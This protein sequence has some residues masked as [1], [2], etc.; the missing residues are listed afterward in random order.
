MADATAH[1]IAEATAAQRR[2]DLAG[3]EAA[4]LRAIE[5]APGNV[6]ALSG[7][8][9]L[10]YQAGHHGP[11]AQRLMEAL[12]AGGPTVAVLV[13]L[14][15]ARHGLG[16]HGGAVASYRQALALKPNFATTHNS[17]GV[18]L[19][20]MKEYKQ[21]K[22][23]FADA[24]KCDPNHGRA[25]FNLATVQREAG[26]AADAVA[27]FERACALSPNFSPAFS[28]LGAALEETGDS[29]GALKA[30]RTAVALDPKDL[31]AINGTAL[32]LSATGDATA[33]EEIVASGLKTAPNDASLNST[34]GTILARK[35]DPGAM[36]AFE[37]AY[38]IAPDVRAHAYNLMLAVAA[39]DLDT[40]DAALA[41]NALKK[42]YPKVFEA[43]P[44]LGVK[45]SRVSKLGEWVNASGVS[46]WTIEPAQEVVLHYGEP[47][48]EDR[49]FA[50]A[51]YVAELRDAEVL[52]GWDYVITADGYVLDN[53]GYMPLIQPFG[54]MPHAYSCRAQKVLHPWRDEVTTIEDPSLFISTP[55]H[56]QIG[57]WIIDFL[58]RLRAPGTFADGRRLKVVIPETLPRRHR[59]MMVHFGV[60]TDQIIEMRWASRYRFRSLHVVG[61]AHRNDPHPGKIHFLH[62]K[63]S[64]ESQAQVSGG[65]FLARSGSNRGRGI[66]NQAEFDALLTE[67]GFSTVRLPEMSISD[68]VAE[69]GRARIVIGTMGSDLSA[70]FYLQPGADVIALVQGDTVESGIERDVRAF[71]RY[72]ATLNIPVHRLVCGSVETETSKGGGARARYYSDLLVDCSELRTMLARLA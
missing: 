18:S 63:F 70:M 67:F 17:L 57:H 32:L 9:I 13:N 71:E 34:L 68:Q 52:S 4:Y 45:I 66:V 28:G 5:A 58:P 54:F 64:R 55:Q 56:F 8:G 2:G 10:Y 35:K 43:D 23:A 3:A 72:G 14:G 16:D 59:E 27:S 12:N 39:G 6:A 53:S 7:L 61:Q 15:L 48:R 37:K 65:I 46:T 41:K 47:P 62:E 24:V 50:E 21:A 31:A 42:S 33:A 30:Y 69:L 20:A 1:L 51:T 25:W 40:V 11:A 19:L 60:R 36:R 26:D 29:Q 38:R 22:E 49:Y 44:A